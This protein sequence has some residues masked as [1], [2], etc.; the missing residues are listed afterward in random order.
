MPRR[1]LAPYNLD[2]ILHYLQPEE[3]KPKR[4]YIRKEIEPSYPLSQG[5]IYGLL[6]AKL[7]PQLVDSVFK[8]VK[9]LPAKVTEDNF[10]AFTMLEYYHL[11]GRRFLLRKLKELKNAKPF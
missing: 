3:V 8:S 7:E 5:I 6:L 2:D 1:K 11:P 9:P 4:V 10:P